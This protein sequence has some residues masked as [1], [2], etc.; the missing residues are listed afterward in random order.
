MSAVIEEV[1]SIR[2]CVNQRCWTQSQVSKTGFCEKLLSNYS[3]KGV[4]EGGNLAKCREILR[5]ED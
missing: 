4:Q 5:A 3:L 1:L 2:G